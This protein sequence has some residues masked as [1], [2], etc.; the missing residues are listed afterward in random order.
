[1]VWEMCAFVNDKICIDPFRFLHVSGT[2]TKQDM[3]MRESFPSNLSGSANNSHSEIRNQVRIH[4]VGKQHGSSFIICHRP[5]IQFLLRNLTTTTHKR[6]ENRTTTY[7]PEPIQ[8]NER[9]RLNCVTC[10]A[11]IHHITHTY[12]PSSSFLHP[13]FIFHFSS[14]P[15]LRFMLH[16]SCFML[17][18]SFLFYIDR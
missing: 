15:F 17:Y 11:D 6:G 7:R 14:R 12:L 1:M 13:F 5:Q 8:S 16:V 9:E 10:S 3:G 4:L 18:A 2:I